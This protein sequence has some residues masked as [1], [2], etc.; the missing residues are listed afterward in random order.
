MRYYIPP[1]Q[2]REELEAEAP[3]SWQVLVL[4]GANIT[5]WLVTILSLIYWPVEGF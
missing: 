1:P 4:I 2:D 5:V 3:T